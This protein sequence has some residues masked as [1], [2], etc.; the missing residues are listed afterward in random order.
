MHPR[1]FYVYAYTCL[2]PR[3]FVYLFPFYVIQ[4]LCWPTRYVSWAQQLCDVVTRYCIKINNFF[5]RLMDPLNDSFV[6]ISVLCISR[7]C[8]GAYVKWVYVYMFVRHSFYFPLLF[9][10]DSYKR[11]VF[12]TTKK[13]LAYKS[14]GKS[15]DR[16]IY[17]S[18]LHSFI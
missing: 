11:T 2:Y 15:S 13:P 9:R 5:L 8:L 17:S 18:L 1:V 6:V 7:V 12:Q 3:V 10:L 4:L 14:L 16:H